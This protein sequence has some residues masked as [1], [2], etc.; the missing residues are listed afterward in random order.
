[1]LLQQRGFF[2][3]NA[4]TQLKQMLG[5]RI[6]LLNQTPNSNSATINVETDDKTGSSQEDHLLQNEADWN[7]ST[8]MNFSYFREQG[9][10]G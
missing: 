6:S 10:Q 9:A 1:M 4:E 7:P 8:G 3:N 2:C 5:L